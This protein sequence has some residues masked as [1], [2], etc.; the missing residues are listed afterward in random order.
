[1]EQ[2]NNF[3]HWC[4]PPIRE[5]KLGMAPSG[6]LM[7]GKLAYI[8]IEIHVDAVHTRLSNSNVI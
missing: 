6:S 1:M 5:Y 4:L 3:K 2:V 7:I 8:I